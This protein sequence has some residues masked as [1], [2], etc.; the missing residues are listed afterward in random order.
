MRCPT[1]GTGIQRPDQ[2]YC[3]ACG[4]QLVS[5]SGPPP[6]P[7]GTG[8]GIVPL[9]KAHGPSPVPD[10]GQGIRL[11]TPAQ[12]A[13]LAMVMPDTLQ[14]RLIVG[15]VTAIVAIFALWMLVNWIVETM[16]HVVLPVGVLLAVIYVGFR[17][18][19]S[20]RSA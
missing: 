1:C 16:I 10:S 15:G 9:G 11:V 14:N 12:R 18:L 20:R 8:Q 6:S 2:R 3:H 19:Q 13:L 5:A 4:V 17:Y 7:A